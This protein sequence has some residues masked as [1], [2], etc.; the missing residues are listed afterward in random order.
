MVSLCGTACT[1]PYIS[2][3]EARYILIFGLTVRT[4]SSNCSASGVQLQKCTGTA[5]NRIVGIPVESTPSS[6]M[7][8]LIGDNDTIKL[9]RISENLFKVQT[10]GQRLKFDQ[11]YDRES[12]LYVPKTRL[13]SAS[14]HRGR[15]KIFGFRNELKQ[16]L[17]PSSA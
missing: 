15:L 1:L 5:I 13:H 10:L 3:D 4:A 6:K 17:K 14:V 12:C 16:N 11:P 9:S 2:A 7:A 8:D